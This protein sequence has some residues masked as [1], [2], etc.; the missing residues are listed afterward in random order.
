MLVATEASALAL[1][2]ALLV[3]Y[4]VLHVAACLVGFA[5]V[6]AFAAAAQI[7]FIAAFQLDQKKGA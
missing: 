4:F 6:L 2:A 7:A 5:I 3:G 1:A